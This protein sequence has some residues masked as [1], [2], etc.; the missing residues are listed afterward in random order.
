MTQNTFTVN[1]SGNFA[2]PGNWTLGHVPNSGEDAE[3]DPSGSGFAVES[4]T[5]TVAS[6]GTATNDGLVIDNGASLFAFNG[7]GPN[8]NDGTISVVNAD[9][10]LNDGTFDN[11][12]L[13]DLEGVTSSIPATLAIT[14]SMT[15]D[16]GGGLSMV[17]GA[18]PADNFIVGD[19]ANTTPTLVNVDNTISGDGTIEGLN[20]TNEA[21]GLIETNNNSSNNA[22]TMQ[23]VGDSTGDAG[24]FTNDGTM[25]I[26]SGG[27][28]VFGQIQNTSLIL[29]Y[30]NI[31]FQADNRFTTLA[32]VGDVTIGVQQTGSGSISMTG[33]TPNEDEIVGQGACAQLALAFQTLD[34]AGT[35]GGGGLS[36]ANEGGTIE[37]DQRNQSL[38]LN[39]GA[40]R[41]DNEGTFSAL[42]G[43]TLEIDSPLQS[44]GTISIFAGGTVV[45]N[46][47]V[48]SSG[49]IFVN[50]GGMLEVAASVGNSITLA[51][52]DAT[53]ALASGGS[54]QDPIAGFQAGDAIDF[55]SLAFA[56]G[57]R[58]V[59]Q[60]NGNSG[61]LSVVDGGGNVLTSLTL[62]GQYTSAEFGTASDSGGGTSIRLLNAAPPGGTTADLIMRDDGA[63]E[64]YDIGGNAI[65]AAY[66]LGQV[67]SQWQ[68]AGLGGFN[69][70]DTSDMLLRNSIDGSFQVDDVS[71]NNITNSVAMGQ[72]GLEWAVAGFGDF[73]SRAGETDM[74]M[75]NSNSGTFEV[76]D[77]SNNQITS[78]ASM[79]QVGLE[80]SV[81][82]FGDFSTQSNETDM[83]MRN[84]N[85]GAFEF[86]D[87]S[88]N[89]ITSAGS[90][91]QVG[92]EWSV[93][94][95]GDFSGNANETD[96]LMRN[97]NTGVL[98]VYDIRGNTIT[99]AAAMGQ[100]GLEW[101]FVGFG[102]ISGAGASDMVMRNSNDGAF[103]I[104]DISNN[105]ITSA[106]PM[107]QVGLEWSV[108]GIA[109]DPP[110]GANAQLA[111]AQLAQIM[112]SFAASGAPPD[113]SLP[114]TA[115]VQ[116]SL[117]TLISMPGA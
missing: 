53:V 93:A 45:L 89:Q 98:E 13:L 107:G 88:N 69:G 11:P 114:G 117:S 84:A 33:Q 104:F 34:G 83:L 37:A 14:G 77:I 78:A 96:M 109:A 80:W 57:S 63:Y 31:V 67:A 56:S 94:G 26:N 79:G 6:I 91:G 17:I 27:E 92:L 75:R 15:L 100:V 18:G 30:G 49:H 113:S 82:G 44:S 112:A 25:L 74:V 36:F 106:A 12:G 72:V 1:G 61:T 71:N 73:S 65:L 43:G 48:T 102:P 54:L 22:G 103:E 62:T 40:N 32:I 52:P 85:T 115:A 70:S 39:T 101:Q 9:L 20:F 111:Q 19:N 35:I 46:A 81:A 95:F 4:N 23:I 24:V 64:I 66:A 76:Y 10:F 7:T 16:G 47:T 97:S 38:I 116:P 5:E 99:S 105:Q 55:T 110:S 90:M 29:N 28:F 60:Q 21:H 58:T 3:I 59:W 86:Y 51:G 8:A 41:I 50:A 108:A 68:V 42:L 2:T 87:I